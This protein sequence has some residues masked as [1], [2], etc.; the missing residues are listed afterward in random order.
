[1]ALGFNKIQSIQAQYIVLAAL[2]GV[3]NVAGSGSASVTVPVSFVDA[4]GVGQ[5]PASYSVQVTPN[6]A[7]VIAAHPTRSARGSTSS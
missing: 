3:A 4:Y 6:Q 1:M 7:G 5:L 2:A